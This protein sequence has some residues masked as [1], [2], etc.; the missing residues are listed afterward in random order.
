MLLI[1]NWSFHYGILEE[2]DRE[3]C[4]RDAMPVKALPSTE[5][6]AAEELRIGGETVYKTESEEMP[7]ASFDR[8]L[9][10]R[11]ATLRALELLDKELD[12]LAASSDVVQAVTDCPYLRLNFEYE[13]RD[14]CQDER[15]SLS[16]RR[17]KLGWKRPSSKETR[18]RKHDQPSRAG[19]CSWPSFARD[20]GASIKHGKS[21]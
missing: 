18:R 17:D 15:F 21:P 19:S 2:T 10:D 1:D 3:R 9:C 12:G 4:Y 20:V 11:L 13:V 7:L 5:M 8:R 14:D 6:N 16:E